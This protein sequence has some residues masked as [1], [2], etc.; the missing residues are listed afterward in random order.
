MESTSRWTSR[1]SDSDT[2]VSRPM[3]PN[4]ARSNSTAFSSAWCGAWSVAMASM[5]PS[6][7]PS[8]IA[9]RSASARNGGFILKL[10]S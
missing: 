9:S 4:G 6:A 3:T 10:V 7:S 5:L 1:S 8:S 2:A